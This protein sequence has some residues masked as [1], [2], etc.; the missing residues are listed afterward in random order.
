[1]I[2]TGKVKI[3]KGQKYLLFLGQKDLSATNGKVIY[4]AIGME[5]GI[6]EINKQLHG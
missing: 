1:M 3:K 5:Q 2:Q 6:V 4:D